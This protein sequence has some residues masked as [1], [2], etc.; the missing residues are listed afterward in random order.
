MRIATITWDF[1][2]ASANIALDGTDGEDV[3]E[4]IRLVC[5]AMEQEPWNE[6]PPDDRTL[7]ERSLQF[8]ADCLSRMGYEVRLGEGC[9]VRV[10]Q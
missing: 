3:S 6:E 7:P 4:G 1:E 10:R 9:E 5:L 8:I 2:K